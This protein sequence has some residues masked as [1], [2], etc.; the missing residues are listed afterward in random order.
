VTTTLD[1]SVFGTDQPPAAHRLV[2]QGSGAVQLDDSADRTVLMVWNHGPET[3]ELFA[4]DGMSLVVAP[5]TESVLPI[6][7]GLAIS[8]R[9]VK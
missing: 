5:N 6:P 3:V 2:V 9:L 7:G 4:E 8:A 1:F